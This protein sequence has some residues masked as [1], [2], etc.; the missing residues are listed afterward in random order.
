MVPSASEALAGVTEIETM[1]AG[2]TVTVV[3]PLTEP[4]LAVM[5]AVPTATAVTRPA[6]ETVAV[7]AEEELHVTVLDRSCVLPSL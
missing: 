1:V 2:V 7:A 5:L 3:V 6:G 4:E